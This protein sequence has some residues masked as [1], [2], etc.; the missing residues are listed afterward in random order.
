MDT[1]KVTLVATIAVIALLAVGIG[2]AL[3][4]QGSTTNTG[5]SASGEYLSVSL[6][7]YQGNETINAYTGFL[8]GIYTLN[9]VTGWDADLNAAA[10]TFNGPYKY[11]NASDPT[12]ID[13]STPG[14]GINQLQVGAFDYS[15]SHFVRAEN[16]GGAYNA[17][18]VSSISANVK[19]TSN[20][21][22][23]VVTLSITGISG[24]LDATI[25]EHGMSLIFEVVQGQN[26]SI[27]DDTT[28]EIDPIVVTM[29]ANG[30]P[31]VTDRTGSVVLNAYILYPKGSQATASVEYQPINFGNEGKTITFTAVATTDNYVVTLPANVTITPAFIDTNKLAAGTLF[32]VAAA[33]GY[34]I[35]G[36]ITVTGAAAIQPTAD[37]YYLMPSHDVTVTATV[38]AD[39]P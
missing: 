6:K 25:Q 26:A 34:H 32:K 1:R 16:E 10:T 36:D 37:G 14:T 3:T 28:S 11:A 33:E 18:K 12:G 27:I 7:D 2:Y 39:Q 13:L 31:N 30:T 35:V 19:Q 8:T 9:T 15:A 38:E 23:S 22:A 24:E 20:Y 4:Y 5:N 29:T 21:T 17:V